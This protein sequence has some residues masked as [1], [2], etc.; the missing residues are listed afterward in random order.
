MRILCINTTGGYFGG[1]E[2]HIAM[3]AR[4]MGERGHQVFFVSK[5][6]DGRDWDAFAEL[7][8]SCDLCSK[9]PL[10]TIVPRISP[11]VI[12]LHKYP[13]VGEV[14]EAAGG[15]PV[16]RMIHDHDIY[17]PRRHKYF[18]HNQAICRRAAGRICYADLAFLER[19]GGRIRFVSVAAKLREL[20]ANRKLDLCIAGS[21]FTRDQLVKNGFAPERIELLHPCVSFAAQAGGGDSALEILYTGQLIRGKGVDILLRAMQRVAE[22]GIGFDRLRIVGSGNAEG[23]LKQLAGELGLADRVTFHGFLPHEELMP[24]YDTAAVVVVPSR[25]PEPFGMVGL[26]AMLRGKPVVGADAG[27]IPDWLEDGVTGFLFQVGSDSSLAEKLGKL[28][29]D[30]E[31]RLAMG[32]AGYRR[33]IRDFSFDRYMDRLETILLQGRPG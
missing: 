8:T 11:D 17:C 29:Q 27:G 33:V 28:L 22:A 13:S 31:L 2:Q 18:F 21:T 1:V 15:V 6:R 10:G 23:G 20:R 19:R 30:A 16:V 26:E 14:L 24:Y 5:N 4:A 32:T 9:E 7:F 25:W 3:V 12:Y